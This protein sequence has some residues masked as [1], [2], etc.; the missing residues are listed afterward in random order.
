MPFIAQVAAGRRTTLK[1]FGNDYPTRDGTGIRD[2]LHVV[3]LARAHL[4][5]V[6]RATQHADNLILNL[7]TGRGYSVLELISA[8]EKQSGHTVNYE[9]VARRPG[10]VASVVADPSCANEVLQWVSQFSLEQMCADGWRWQ[11]QNPCGFSPC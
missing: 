1:V 5:A 3:D 11:Q 10:D 7:G 2:Y 6:E 9:I 8:F 4:K